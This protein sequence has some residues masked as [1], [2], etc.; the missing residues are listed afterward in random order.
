MDMGFTR[1]HAEEALLVSG[2][3][4]A[5]A[6]EWILTHPPSHTA[7]ISSREPYVYYT[8]T[9]THTCICTCTC[10]CTCMCTLCA[11]AHVQEVSLYMYIVYNRLYILLSFMLYLSLPSSSSSVVAGGILTEDEQLAHAIA[12][13]PGPGHRD[14]GPRHLVLPRYLHHRHHIG[15]H[16]L[17]HHY[18]IRGH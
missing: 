9:Y 18:H 12:L 13:R 4:L 7:T 17:E 3:E 16:H 5:T 8:Y 11:D 15:S 6:M 10:T 1:E 14:T 2:N